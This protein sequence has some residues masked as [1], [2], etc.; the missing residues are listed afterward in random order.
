VQLP[1]KI[2]EVLLFLLARLN[3][4]RDLKRWTQFYTS[5]FPEIYT[6]CELFA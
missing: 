3:I 6:V 2:V 1:I 4:E 5:I